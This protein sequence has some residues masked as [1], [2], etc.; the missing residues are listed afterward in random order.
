MRGESGS[1]KL[2]S[3]SSHRPGGQNVR[4]PQSCPAP[5]LKAS[6]LEQPGHN[7]PS[8]PSR[9]LYSTPRGWCG[10]RQGASR[11]MPRFNPVPPRFVSDDARLRADRSKVRKSRC[12]GLSRSCQGSC[13]MPPRSVQTASKVRTRSCQGWCRS[14]QGSYEIIPRFV[15]FRSHPFPSRLN[16]SDLRQTSLIL[17]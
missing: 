6:R 5:A 1:A 9:G 16:T 11:L 3:L 10:M 14:P 12:Q 15:Q 17:F 7:S 4:P 8:S 2:I 13:G